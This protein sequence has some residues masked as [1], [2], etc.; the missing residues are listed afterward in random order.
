MAT[1]VNSNETPVYYAVHPLDDAPEQK[2]SAEGLGVIRMSKSVK[3]S[4][5]T[6]RVYLVLILALALYRL[7]D[8]LGVFG[9]HVAK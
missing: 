4:L 3:A 9:H 1:S 7:V 8:L 5:V 6:L 2:R